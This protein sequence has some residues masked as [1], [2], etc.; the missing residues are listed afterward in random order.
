ML[1]QA[2]EEHKRCTLKIPENDASYNLADV[3]LTNEKFLRP[4]YTS[5][6]LIDLITRWLRKTTKKKKSLQP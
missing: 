3:S 1:L 2:E 4:S 6:K 5:I